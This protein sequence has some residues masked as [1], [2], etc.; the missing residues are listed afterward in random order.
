MGTDNPGTPKRDPAERTSAIL[1]ILI[2]AIVLL[3][4]LVLATS[5]YQGR[6]DV[7]IRKDLKK[8]FVEIKDHGEQIE[9]TTREI[10]TEREV[11]Q[12]QA[13]DLEKLREDLSRV[14]AELVT[15][16]GK[17]AELRQELADSKT[18]VSAVEAQLKQIADL[19]SIL[20]QLRGRMSDGLKQ[21]EELRDRVDELEKERQDNDDR[22]R[23]IEEQLQIGTMP[24]RE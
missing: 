18:R 10:A 6:E 24:N 12:Q 21:R 16:E 5:W 23:R 22:L 19:Q 17:L 20:E 3:A 11:N 2:A 1:R 4:L 7:A 9:A 15:A 13:T 8:A 14:Q